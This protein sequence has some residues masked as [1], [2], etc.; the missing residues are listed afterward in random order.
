M[1]R[2]SQA[3]DNTGFEMDDVEF[4]VLRKTYLLDDAHG[5]KKST[6]SENE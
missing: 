4:D 6:V 5:F 2:R 3:H 1:F